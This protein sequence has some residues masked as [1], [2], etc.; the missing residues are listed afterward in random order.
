MAFH[1]CADDGPTKNAGLVASWFLRGSG[2]VLLR[3]PI[4]LWFFRGES[5]PPVLPSGSTHDMPHTGTA[6]VNNIITA[7]ISML[8]CLPFILISLSLGS[9]VCLSFCHFLS[10]LSL[11]SLLHFI[12]PLPPFFLYTTFSLSSVLFLLFFLPSLISDVS[13]LSFFLSPHSPPLPSV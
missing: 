11:L 6:C 4:L 5:G 3:N 10:Y 8:P 12:S 2:P 1:W 7:R 13:L 9:S